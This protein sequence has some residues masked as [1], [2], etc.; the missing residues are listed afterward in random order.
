MSSG[1][2]DP[3]AGK[4]D[5]HRHV[6]GRRLGHESTQVAKDG[7]VEREVEGTGGPFGL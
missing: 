3:G 1:G 2:G 5:H 4:R 7:A 6:V